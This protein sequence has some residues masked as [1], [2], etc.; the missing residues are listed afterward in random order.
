[1]KTVKYNMFHRSLAV[2]LSALVLCFACITASSTGSK[3]LVENGGYRPYL[4]YNV[5][6]LQAGVPRITVINVYLKA[7]EKLYFGSSVVNSE[8]DI[9]DNQKG[10]GNASG[11]DIVLEKPDGTKTGYNNLVG[12]NSSGQTMQPDWTS[13]TKGFIK[14]TAMEAAGPKIP[15]VNDNPDGYTPHSFTATEDGIYKLRFHSISGSEKDPNSYTSANPTAI[16]VTDEWFQEIN[17]Y[18]FWADKQ[19]RSGVAAWDATVV[20]TD[21]EIKTGRIFTK[22]LFLYAHGKDGVGGLAEKAP[23]YSNMYAVTKD[24]YM[25]NIDFN[26]MMPYGF[27][28]FANN[29]GLVSS[30]NNQPLYQSYVS[31]QSFDQSGEQTADSGAEDQM[32]GLIRQGVTFKD[33]S[34]ADTQLDSSYCL[35]FDEPS[36]ELEGIIYQKAYEP[37]APTNVSFSGTEEGKTFEGGGGEISFDVTTATMATVTVDMTA[38]GKGVVKISN[39]VVPGRNSFFWD[40]CGE[41]GTPIPARDEPYSSDEIKI[42]VDVRSG[43]C[44]FP[45]FDVE[46][47]PDGIKLKRINR[48]YRQVTEDGSVYDLDVTDEYDDPTGPNYDKYN[49]NLVRYNNPVLD[50]ERNADGSTKTSNY[51]KETNEGTQTNISGTIGDSQNRSDGID[52]SEGALKY[53]GNPSRPA[54]MKWAYGNQN[55]LDIWT[56]LSASAAVVWDNPIEIT[57]KK[58]TSL[59]G[60]VFYDMLCD[61]IEAEDN[62]YRPN[63]KD[64]SLEGIRV[65]LN[66]SYTDPQGVPHN[67]QVVTYTDATGKYRFPNIPVMTESNDNTTYC[68]VEIEKPLNSYKVT[69]ANTTT[70]ETITTGTVVQQI[71]ISGDNATTSG[72][73]QAYKPAFELSDVGFNYRLYDKTV[74]LKKDWVVDISSDPDRPSKIDITIGAFKSGDIAPTKEYTYTL[75]DVNGWMINLTDLPAWDEADVEDQTFTYKIV[76]EEYTTK[77]G[78]SYT[79]TESNIIADS[80]PYNT[81][82][83][84]NS[85]IDTLTLTAKNAPKNGSITVKKADKDDQTKML[86]GVKFKIYYK[87][88][89]TSIP[90]GMEDQYV[91]YEGNIYKFKDEG[92]TN[93]GGMLTF[94]NLDIEGTY[95]IKETEAKDGYKLLETPEVITLSI[96]SF[97]K[98]W[99]AL[100]EKYPPYTLNIKK[101]N[102]AG[103]PLADA[104]FTIY[105]DEDCTK[106]LDTATTVMNADETLAVATFDNLE[107]AKGGKTYFIKE[108]VAPTGYIC[109]DSVMSVTFD[110]DIDDSM[111]ITNFA[112]TVA[113]VPMSDNTATIEV[114][115]VMGITVPQT[116]VPFG[117]IFPLM[118]SVLCVL[119]LSILVIGR[120]TRH[121]N[122]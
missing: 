82:F 32:E 58:Y 4:E 30:V 101:I 89:S 1:M 81:E 28:F 12:A 55:A 62:F 46:E 18:P 20:G 100:N 45:F 91:D 38:I 57:D 103:E 44:H 27:M 106:P 70:N 96:D 41:D 17:Y 10:Y 3:E 98:T 2:V 111:S 36:P 24:G 9:N 64:F 26:G 95:L 114:T 88:G 49:P 97:N 53:K 40:G 77:A 94:K 112:G 8:L 79:I 33:P 6:D 19:G 52:S 14:N 47:M 78:D 72:D 22:S 90:S 83:L 23:I 84:S 66:Y 71:N 119:S 56:Y 75:N 85:G 60:N 121:N 86:S 7:G 80:N 25:Y 108:T 73:V 13:S 76:K 42:S 50:V 120:K 51:N 59:S 54:D 43:E 109:P 31:D 117:I 122:I 37:Q 99:I 92:V 39:P 16:K 65:T 15:G 29:R 68:T 118:G 116:G 48:I 105:A 115:N 11:V 61:D 113:T 74:Q 21:N 104:E 87:D 5:E 67:E 107:G 63:E 93:G 34:V 110:F 35:F 69:T 102:E